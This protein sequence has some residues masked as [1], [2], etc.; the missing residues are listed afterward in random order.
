M[1]FFRV[2][3]R[4]VYIYFVVWVEWFSLVFF[5]DLIKIVFKMD[6]FV[7]DRLKEIFFFWYSFGEDIFRGLGVEFWVGGRWLG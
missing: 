1:G 7:C 4:L 3:K 5:E 2:N 6:Y